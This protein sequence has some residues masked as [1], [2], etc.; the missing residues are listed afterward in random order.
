MEFNEKLQELR[1]QKELTQ[2]ELARALFVSRTAVSKWESGRGYPNLD[3]LKAIAV[4]F[5]VTVDELLSGERIL[6]LAREESREK[7]SRLRDLVFGLLDCSTALFF[8]VP[9][10]RQNGAG[11]VQAVSLPALTELASYLKIGYF[12]VVVALI[13]WG[14]LI[15]VLQ[16][17]HRPFRMR[18]K[19]LVSL[20][21]NAAGALLFIVSLQPYAA[22][23]LFLFLTIKG[24]LLLKRQ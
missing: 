22:A 7:E 14:V 24:L 8:F 19:Q 6:T 18:S 9:F 12:A 15:L 1:K 20:M 2:E 3:S 5:G 16:N 4:F 11:G 23:L 17:C 10:F 21:L 13:V